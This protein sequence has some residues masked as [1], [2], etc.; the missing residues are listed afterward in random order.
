MS[1][2]EAMELALF[3]YAIIAPVAANLAL[4]MS[5]EAFFREAAE[6][7]YTLPNGKTVKFKPTTLKSWW[8]MYKKDGL[9]GLKPKQRIDL[10]QSRLITPEIEQRI[11]DL[12]SKF[13]RIT[14]QKIWEKMIEDGTITPT[15]LSVDTVQRYLKK[16]DLKNPPSPAEKE[17]LAFEFAHVND[18]WQTDT[19]DGP[20]ITDEKGNTRKTFLISIHDDHSRKNVSGR[21]F[22]NDNAVNMQITFKKAVKVAG[23]PK[24]LIMDNGGSYNNGQFKEICAELGV[25]AVYLRPYA[26]EGKGKEERS[27]RTALDRFIN[28][29]D[30]SDCHDLET[31]NAMYERYI[32]TDYNQAVNRMTQSSP[33]ARFMAEYDSIRFVDAGKLDIVFLHRGKRRL[34]SNSTIQYNNK[35]YE[36]P[37]EYIAKMRSRKDKIP[38]RYDP[39]D[40]TQLY[41]V[42]E[43][44]YAVKYIL[45][46]V[47]LAGNSNRHRKA[48][49][50]YSV[51]IG[52]QEAKS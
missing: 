8:L 14:G 45:K 2:E 41:I 18:C 15:T 52:G 10:G 33:N 49:V 29:T 46:P 20:Y 5:K 37:Q 28:C 22:Y 3:R 21:L 42:D 50:D 40:N 16:S 38:F 26:P 39:S 31:L 48:L 11:L 12:K 1:D 27:H 6:K 24:M 25:G 34:Y 44:T 17:K 13:P 9:Q 43:Q 51:A 19:V 7:G 47:N 23:V 30:F 36:V 32:N 4:D 35:L